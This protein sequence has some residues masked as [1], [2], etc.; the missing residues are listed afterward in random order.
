MTTN[1]K[2]QIMP[3]VDGL[4][5]GALSLV[6]IKIFPEYTTF[7][8]LACLLYIVLQELGRSL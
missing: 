4:L 8:I 7:F 6:V 2:Q 5:A 3:V 1:N